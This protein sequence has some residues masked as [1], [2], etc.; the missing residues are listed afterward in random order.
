MNRAETGS[1]V[2]TVGVFLTVG[3]S[4][5]TSM[6]VRQ[7]HIVNLNRISAWLANI[8]GLRPATVRKPLIVATRAWERAHPFAALRA[9]FARSRLF[10]LAGGTPALPATRG[11]G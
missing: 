4:A 8:T 2:A 1:P 6:L 11:E 3:F 10:S 7:T 5:V 9:G